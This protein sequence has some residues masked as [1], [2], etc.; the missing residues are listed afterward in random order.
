LAEAIARH[1]LAQ[2]MNVADGEL[3]RKW[4][5]VISA[6]TAAMPGCRATPQAVEAVAALGADLSRHRSQPLSVE[7]IH[8]A[9]VIW[10][11]SRNHVRSVMAMV[12]SAAQKVELLNVDKDVDD[13]IGGD[14]AL[15]QELAGEMCRFMEKRLKEKGLL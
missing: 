2:A 3:E 12:P 10:A 7:L 6:G 1:I 14:N 13:P 4:I 11:M 5:T 15:Y 9:D 8:Q